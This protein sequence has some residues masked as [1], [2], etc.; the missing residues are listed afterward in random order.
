MEDRFVEMALLYDFYG[1]ILTAKQQEIIEL[2]YMKNFSLGEIGELLKTSRQAVYD[3]LKRAEKQLN[4]IE[5]R[6]GL[7]CRYQREEKQWSQ[8]IKRL[9]NVIMALDREY[10]NH[11]MV[12]ELQDIREFI[13]S[14]TGG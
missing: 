4:S 14:I 10:S 13:G 8:T 5:D 9:D 6:L 2:Y 7:V 3:N 11:E 12:K 1:K